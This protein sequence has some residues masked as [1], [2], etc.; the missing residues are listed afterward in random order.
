MLKETYESLGVPRNEKKAVKNAETAEMQGAW[1]DGNKGVCSPK[2][3]KVGKYLSSLVYVLHTKKVTQKQLQMLVGGLVYMFSFRRPLMSILNEVWKFILDF[4]ND[5]QLKPLPSEVLAELWACFYMSVFSFMNFRMDIDP[6]VTAS[7]ASESGGGLVAS[8]GLTDWGKR[9][10]QGTIRG[11]KVEDFQED[12]L[13]VISLFD[14]LGSLRLALDGLKV[15]LAGYI[16]VEQNPDAQRVLEG[17][18]PSSMC[19]SDVAQLTR[20]DIQQIAATFPNCRAVLL[21]GGPPCQGV[22]Q[23]NASKRGAVDDPRSSLHVCF[24]RIK[25]WVSEVFTWCPSFFLMES[26]ASMND[27]DRSIYTRSSGVLPYKIDSYH[28]APCK[29]PRLWWFNWVIQSKEGIN[30]F[31]PTTNQ[32]TD[33]GEIQFHYEYQTKHFLRTGWEPAGQKPFLTFTTAQPSKKPR[34]KPAGVEKATERDLAAWK[35]DRHRFPPYAYQYEN[36]VIHKRKGWRMLDTQEKELMM[37]LPLDYTEQC[38]PKG[39]RK[40]HPQ[41]TE[42]T[43][44][45]LI[46][47]AWHVGVVANLLQHL[48]FQLGLLPDQ[49]VS[50]VMKQLKPGSAADAAGLLLREGFERPKPFHTV[51]QNSQDQ[52]NLVRKLNH[53]VSS[54]G[55]DVL[56]TTG[57]ESMPKQHRLRNS[58]SPKL[59]RWKVLCGWKW[60]NTAHSVPEHINKLEMRAVET[61]LR[62]HLFRHRA[63]GKRV[64]HLVDSMVSLQ[65]INKGRTSSRKIRSVSK[66]IAAL[67]I[68]GNLLLTLAYTATATNPADAPSRRGRKRK[69]GDVK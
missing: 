32:V 4:S 26:V 10:S 27:K 20:E 16:S 34:Y 51:D 18:F 25:G 43:R 15:S 68:S 54:K 29:R 62:W 30:I 8:T 64:L 44:L 12:G 33:F 57:S 49:S 46:G 56:L 14:G 31:P 22:S 45:S 38:K 3:D 2:P 47:N 60:R 69:W 50:D 6:T 7:D 13:L 40:S 52:L 41:E 67:L 58:L 42:D 53:L 36:G 19:Y 9:V 28:L 11:E 5:K 65:I 59:W 17:H 37:S 63:Y 61:A 55:T 39:F 23:L 48:C 66:R 21:G 35:E 1:I 24:D